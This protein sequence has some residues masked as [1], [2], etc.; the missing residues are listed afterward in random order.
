MLTSHSACPAARRSCSNRA[1]KGFPRL[2][3]ANVSAR[4]GTFCPVGCNL[5]AY[6]TVF[7]FRTIPGSMIRRRLIHFHFCLG[8]SMDTCALKFHICFDYFC[9][10]LRDL[11]L[12]AGMH[13]SGNPSIAC[14]VRSHESPFR[15]PRI[16]THVLLLRARKGRLDIDCRPDWVFLGEE[17]GVALHD[18]L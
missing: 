1:R 9:T 14:N 2:G 3:P 17:T 4:F 12:E 16:V 18:A 8:S 15:R 5:Q 13:S 7:S 10:W 11:A 6:A